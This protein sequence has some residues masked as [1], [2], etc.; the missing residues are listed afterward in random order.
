MPRTVLSAPMTQARTSAHARTHTPTLS[1]N[2][3]NTAIHLTEEE[4]EVHWTSRSHLSH[5]EQ[6]GNLDLK[7]GRPDPES[8]GLISPPLGKS[9]IISELEKFQFPKGCAEPTP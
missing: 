1:L 6:Q 3:Q 5:D 4:T 7:P 9:L 8:A 2:T